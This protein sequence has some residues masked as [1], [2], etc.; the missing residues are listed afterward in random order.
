MLFWGSFVMALESWSSSFQLLL[1][2]DS[3]RSDCWLSSHYCL[4]CVFDLSFSSHLCVALLLT[5]AV[6]SV[7]RLLD[8][9]LPIVTTSC[10]TGRGWRPLIRRLWGPLSFP[11]FLFLFFCPHRATVRPFRDSV[12]THHIISPTAPGGVALYFRTIFFFLY[13]PQLAFAPRP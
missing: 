1:C 7:I 2:L 6:G 9:A 10:T 3:S 5:P 11:L 4:L 13:Q 8:I 12:V